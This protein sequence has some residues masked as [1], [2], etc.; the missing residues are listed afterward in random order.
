MEIEHSLYSSPIHEWSI[1]KLRNICT[2]Q[3]AL[4]EFLVEKKT[5]IFL[6][7]KKN[8]IHKIF[9]CGF[10]QMHTQKIQVLFILHFG[11]SNETFV[12][13]NIR[14]PIHCLLNNVWNTLQ[15]QENTKEIH[16]VSHGN[17]STIKIN[18]ILNYYK[19]T[20]TWKS[21]DSKDL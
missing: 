17:C 2:N 11:H 3:N 12:I 1:N 9:V 8:N 20:R 4:Q 13:V 19:F 7:M 18:D 16:K 6:W 10:K 5:Q 15:H 14:L 21:L